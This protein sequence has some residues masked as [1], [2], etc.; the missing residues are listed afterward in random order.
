NCT[1]I[2]KVFGY[3]ALATIEQQIFSSSVPFMLA[4]SRRFGN[5]SPVR[6]VYLLK[7]NEDGE[8][9]SVCLE[10]FDPWDQSFV[11]PSRHIFHSLCMLNWVHI[12]LDFLCPSCRQ[13]MSHPNR[14]ANYV[15]ETLRWMMAFHEFAFDSDLLRIAKAALL[16]TDQSGKNGLKMARL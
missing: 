8:I 12:S 4:S 7:T 1:T 2:S 14:E 5:P 16:L 10:V 3:R 15:A 9:C 11:S 6:L 13:D